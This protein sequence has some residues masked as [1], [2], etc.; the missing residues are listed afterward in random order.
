MSAENEFR[1]LDRAIRASGDIAQKHLGDYGADRHKPRYELECRTC[2][3]T[4]HVSDGEDMPYYAAQRHFDGRAA[5]TIIEVTD[6]HRN[7]MEVITRSD[8]NE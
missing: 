7:D 2:G 6:R 1:T 4:A 5:C 8:L 3:K